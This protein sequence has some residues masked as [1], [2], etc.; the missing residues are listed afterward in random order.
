MISFKNLIENFNSYIKI[1]SISTDWLSKSYN[2]SMGL[3]EE[4]FSLKINDKIMEM[5]TAIA[6]LFIRLVSKLNVCR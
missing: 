5:P 3:L 2:G 4:V 1:T 6:I